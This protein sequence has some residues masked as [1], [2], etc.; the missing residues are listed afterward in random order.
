MTTYPYSGVHDCVTGSCTDAWDIVIAGDAVRSSAEGIAYFVRNDIP[1]NTCDP[2]QGLG[3]NVRVS[4][5][6]GPSVYYGHLASTPVVQGSRILQGDSIGVQGHTGYTIGNDPGGCG[7]HLHF[8]F[9]PAHPAKIDNA[10]N[11][12]ASTNSAVGHYSLP[13]AA[14]RLRYWGLGEIGFGPSWGVVGWT[15]DWTGSQGGCTPGSFC[16][17]Y[18]HYAPDPV[19]GHWGSVQTFRKHPGAAVTDDGSIMVG[20]WA[21]NDAWRV[22]KPFF[23]AWLGG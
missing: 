14:I 16:Q 9:V 13:G 2:L 12:S 21:V 11:P 18:V 22:E 15:S 1:A 8:E 19:V 6:N 7:T 3:N 4:V 20:R 17:L 23:A 10:T 5:P